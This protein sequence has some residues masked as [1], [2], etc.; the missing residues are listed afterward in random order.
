MKK[1]IILHLGIHKTATTYLQHVLQQN[2]TLLELADIKVHT[3]N[4]LRKSKYH[5]LL[6]LSLS[7][8]VTLEKF[9]K[10]N[11]ITF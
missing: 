5:R 8:E 4:T 2:S 9:T 10:L 7:D 3:P 11:P 1:N 6:R